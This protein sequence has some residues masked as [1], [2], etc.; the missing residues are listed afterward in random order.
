MNCQRLAG[1]A[2][3]IGHERREGYGRS[4]VGDVERDFPWPSPG[5]DDVNQDA[6][7]GNEGSHWRWQKKCTNEVRDRRHRHL[8]AP[9]HDHR[10]AFRY[11]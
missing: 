2:Q 11:D 7:A 5:T 9:G 1:H 6:A 10:A 3:E 4:G 8:R